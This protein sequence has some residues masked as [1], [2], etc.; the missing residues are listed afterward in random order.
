MCLA[1]GCWCFD[2]VLTHEHDAELARIVLPLEYV[3]FAGIAASW[4]PGIICPC[5]GLG[6]MRVRGL[7]RDGGLAVLFAVTAHGCAT[8][9]PPQRRSGAC[10]LNV[11]ERPIARVLQELQRR[12]ETLIRLVEKENEDLDARDGGK[13]KGKAAGSKGGGGGSS[14]KGG[15]ASRCVPCVAHTRLAFVLLLCCWVDEVTIM[16]RMRAAKG[17]ASTRRSAHAVRASH[18]GRVHAALDAPLLYHADWHVSRLPSWYFWQGV[19]WHGLI[20]NL[21]TGSSMSWCSAAPGRRVTHR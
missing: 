11:V 3:S 21:L 7:R 8:A 20:T 17:R 9:Q 6:C 19:L 5:T 1:R 2:K 14:S 12:C 13:A 10:G 15:D 16:R 4:R 18:R